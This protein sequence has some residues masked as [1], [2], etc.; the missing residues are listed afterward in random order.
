MTSKFNLEGAEA[1]K[2]DGGALINAN[3]SNFQ[4]LDRLSIQSIKLEPGAFREPH[5]HP[6]ATQ[7]DYCVAGEAQVGIV[8]HNGENQLF[9]LKSG[10]IS[11]VPQGHL[12]WIKNAGQSTLHMILIASHEMPETIEL[13]QMLG[14]VPNTDLAVIFGIKQEIFDEIPQTT[15]AVKAKL[16]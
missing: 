13:S 5:V 9:D 12:H 16:G 11:F 4:S 7:L 6:N 10:E 2:F 15:N 3:K 14:G 1:I 8:G